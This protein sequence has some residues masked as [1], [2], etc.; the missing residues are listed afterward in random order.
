M[1]V[2]ETLLLEDIDLVN[3]ILRRYMTLLQTLHQRLMMSQSD[4]GRITG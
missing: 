3:A 4:Q 1:H 2:H